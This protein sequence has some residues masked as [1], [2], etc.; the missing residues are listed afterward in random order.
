MTDDRIEKL[1]HRF[2]SQ[3]LERMEEI[4]EGEERHWVDMIYGWMLGQG[5]YT[6]KAHRLAFDFATEIA[7]KSPEILSIKET[8]AIFSKYLTKENDH[9]EKTSNSNTPSRSRGMAS[10]KRV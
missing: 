2:M 6:V 9:N 10:G 4:D 8:T 3:I 7:T 1:S 5:I